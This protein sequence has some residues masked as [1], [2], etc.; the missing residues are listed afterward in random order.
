MSLVS[1]AAFRFGYGLPAAGAVTAETMLVALAG[2]D[3]A[4][5]AYPM[6]GI[7]VLGPLLQQVQ[8]TKMA[9]KRDKAKD[10]EFRVVQAEADQVIGTMARATFARAIEAEGLRERLVAF[11]ADHFTVSAKVLGGIGL[12]L[13]LVEEAIRPHLTGNFEAMLTAVTLHPVMVRYL[14]QHT[15]FGPNSPRG[16]QRNVGLNENLARELLELHTLGVGAG[17]SQA[18]VRQM[19]ELLTG[20]SLSKDLKVG[21]DRR[22]AEPGAETVLGKDYSGDGMAPIR[23]VLRDLALRP[24][25][26]VHIA[27]KLAVHFVADAPDPA[28]VA[29]MA[30][31]WM[32]TGGNLLLVYRAMLEHPAAWAMPLAKVRQPYDFIIASL[33]ALGISGAALMGF[34]DKAMRRLIWQALG[35]MGQPY[36]SPRGPDGWAEAAEYWITPQG[37]AQRIS[38]AM[39]AP[40]QMQRLGLIGALPDPGALAGAGL[41]DLASETLLVAAGRAETLAEGVG[42]VLA[43]PEFNRR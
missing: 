4:A 25:T 30:E 36:K 24:E 5:Q 15:S 20:I 34:E 41:G 17:Y 40:E 9:A 16:R 43:S 13:A 2:P 6:A 21:F 31:A 22:R 29:A 19:A 3:L 10:A 37:L 18:D 32:R 26:A 1:I 14:D 28:L 8:L 12:P 42:L 38:W 11:W 35:D 23:Q 39:R 7:S 33:R 27:R